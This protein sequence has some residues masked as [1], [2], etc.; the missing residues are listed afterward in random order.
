MTS[1]QAG[2]T[3]IVSSLD[4]TITGKY[5]INQIVGAYI[6]PMN[7]SNE[8][9]VIILDGQDNRWKVYDAET[10]FSVDIES[11]I[12][13]KNIEQEVIRSDPFNQTEIILLKLISGDDDYN[14]TSIDI[15]FHDIDSALVYLTMKINEAKYVFDTCSQIS[16]SE[17]DDSCHL[18]NFLIGLIFNRTIPQT[19]NQF[20][21]FIEHLQIMPIHK[22]EE[23]LTD[24]SGKIQIIKVSMLN[25]QNMIK[26]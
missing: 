3:V 24:Y 13:P 1:V 11:P 23:T 4:G 25:P 22:I 21:K 8:K 20:I 10:Q 15:A 9:S 7:N 5:I 26:I 2:N 6:S 17:P 19:S 16:E 12:S 18:L 14:I